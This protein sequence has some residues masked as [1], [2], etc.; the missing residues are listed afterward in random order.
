[1]HE[2]AEEPDDDDPGSPL[3][4]R[5]V[6]GDVDRLLADW[7]VTLQEE[8]TRAQV[9][10]TEVAKTDKTGW[11]KRTG[12]LEHFQ[13]RNLV[14]LAHQLRRLDRDEHKLRRVTDLV[15][16]LVES[17]VAGLST[18]ARETRRWLRALSNKSPT[19]GL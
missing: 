1:M 10:A 6:Q 9:M 17:S 14:H 8:E 18:L 13:G 11:F 5:E 7:N 2:P 15:E 3:A 19:C 16:G 4:S 12:W